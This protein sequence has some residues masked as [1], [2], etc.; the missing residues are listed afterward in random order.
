MNNLLADLNVNEK[1]IVILNGK[2]TG[3]FNREVNDNLM[4]YFEN[5]PDLLVSGLWILE[6]LSFCFC[7]IL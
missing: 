5:V 2:N 1:T 4:M 3:K 7:F 6:S